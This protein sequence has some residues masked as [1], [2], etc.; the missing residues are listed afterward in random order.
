MYA[1]IA[2][3]S[4]QYRVEEGL[5]FEIQKPD[6]AEDTKTVT[7]ERVLMVGDLPDGPKVGAP[8]VAGAKVRASVIGPIKGDKLT[9]QKFSRRK[10]YHL[11]KGH[12]QKYLQVKVE[13]IEF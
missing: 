4:H 9:I 3:G 13:A 5:I 6:L 1:I 11:K 8:M 7:F 12:R 2:D 10:G